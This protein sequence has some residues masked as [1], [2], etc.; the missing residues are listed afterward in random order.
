MNLVVGCHYLPPGL[1]STSQPESIT[2]PWPVAKYGRQI[3][4]RQTLFRQTLFRQSAVKTTQYIFSTLGICRNRP[5]VE[6]GK[7]LEWVEAL[8]ASKAQHWPRHWGDWEKWSLGRVSQWVWGAPSS[9]KVT[10][11]FQHNCTAPD[12]RDLVRRL[13]NRYTAHGRR[14]NQLQST[15]RRPDCAW[16]VGI[17]SVG[18][19]SVGIVWCQIILFGDRGT[20]HVCEPLDQS[21]YLA[22]ECTGIARDLS[23]T[24]LAP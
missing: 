15:T 18:T 4:F 17:A 21:H 6:I 1:W 11:Y 8:D 5:L 13:S 3:L 20:W 9:G 16:T 10:T 7:K 2:A 12:F 19:E 22:A 23:T 24:I 14:P